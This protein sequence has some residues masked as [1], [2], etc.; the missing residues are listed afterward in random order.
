MVPGFDFHGGRLRVHLTVSGKQILIRKLPTA[1]LVGSSVG[2]D[3]VGEL[4]FA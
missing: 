2:L 3:P 4:A 1:M